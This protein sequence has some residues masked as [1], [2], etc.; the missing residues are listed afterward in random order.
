MLKNGMR[1][2]EASQRLTAEAAALQAA[3]IGALYLFGSTGRDEAGPESDVDL[4]FDPARAGLSLFDVMD[5]R[6]RLSGILGRRVDVMTRSSL[7]PYLRSRIEAEAI[8][9]F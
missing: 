6:D 1:R 4:F 9:V 3:G 5:L 7:H 2:D 8:R